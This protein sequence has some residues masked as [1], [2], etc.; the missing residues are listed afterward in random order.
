MNPIPDQTARALKLTL[1]SVVANSVLVVVKL[2][3][4]LLGNSY[5]L[6]A[7]A[8]ESALDIVGSL[9]LWSGV[10]IGAIPPDGN[11]PYG[12]GKAEPLAA[13]ILGISLLGAAAFLA[14]QSVG[15]IV[16]PR[17]PPEA[18]TLIVLFIVVLVKEFLYR[19]VLREGNAINSTVLRTDAWHHRTD[20][21]TS[22]VAFTGIAISL[23]GGPGYESADA[24]AALLACVIIAFNGFRMLRPALAEVM[25]SAPPP[26][27]EA[28]VRE[29]AGTV[30]GVAGLEQCRVRKYGIV[31]FV[32]LHVEVDGNLTV[33]RGHEIAHRVKD[34][35]LKSNL[36]IGD[37]LIHIE[38]APQEAKGL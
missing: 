25:D 23:K 33:Y 34:K 6:I 17:P 1:I 26:D 8:M 31:F 19:L 14:T 22:V 28:S 2:L 32:D 30:E 36:Q 9:I 10:K 35:L 24:W 7:D 20:A 21:I 29:L 37:V 38:P 15:A 11:H 13:L 12:H 4:G 27:I 3:S 18:F 5:A 16:T